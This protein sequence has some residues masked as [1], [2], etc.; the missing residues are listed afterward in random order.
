[1]TAP[2]PEGDPSLALGTSTMTLIE[3]IAAYA[4]VAAN[5]F[6]IKPR[7]VPAE[8]QSWWDWL[9]TPSDSASSRTH[10][11]IERMLRAAINRGTGEA[12][13]LPVANFGKTGTTQD[14]RDALFVGYAGWSEGQLQDDIRFGSWILFAGFRQQAR[15]SATCR[16]VDGSVLRAANFHSCSNVWR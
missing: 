1:M 13:E 11:D 2:L 6:P 16:T 4:G 12:E 9:M 5:Q 10:A 15:F 7:A 8:E 3:L 14:Y